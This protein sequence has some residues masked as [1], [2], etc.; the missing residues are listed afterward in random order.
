MMTLD[1]AGGRVLV[2]DALSH[3]LL[4]YSA[5]IARTGGSELLRI[6]VLTAEGVRGL[7]DIVVGPASQL[8]STPTDEPEA[9]L[10]D[11]E[12][13]SEIRARLSALQPAHAIPMDLQPD[14]AFDSDL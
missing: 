8:L 2:S 4:E 3:A 14:S 5:T 7:A 1:Y 13:I 11:S 10:D 9:D 12:V 6:P